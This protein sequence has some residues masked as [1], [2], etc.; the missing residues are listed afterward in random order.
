L[1]T[2]KRHEIIKGKPAGGA[3]KRQGEKGTDVKENK[4]GKQWE[5]IPEKKGNLFDSWTKNGDYCTETAFWHLGEGVGHG[6]QNN[7]L[8]VST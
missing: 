8:S 4:Q 1:G 6:A 5:A 2:A 3:I 7:S